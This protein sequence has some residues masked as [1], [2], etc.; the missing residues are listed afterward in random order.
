MKERPIDLER[1]VVAH[2]E[3]AKVAVP[4]ERALYGPAPFIAPQDTSILRRHA[5][6]VRAVRR[7][8]QN[9]SLP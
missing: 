4:C 9:T 7:D 2:N 1:T 8:Q 5:M 3:S 6:A